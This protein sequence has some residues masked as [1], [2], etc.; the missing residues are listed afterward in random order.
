MFI[1][2]ELKTPGVG[3]WAL[4]GGVCGALF[5]VAQY[6]L[7]MINHVEIVLVVLGMI[8][9]VTE[10][11]TMVGG[12]F[13]ALVGG[14]I[15]FTG[16]VMAFLPNEFEF[17]LSDER[18]LNALGDA[19]ISGLIAIGVMA[20]G[21]V[22]FIYALPRTSLGRRLSVTS[23]VSATSAGRLEALMSDLVG[24]SG[25]AC[26]AMHPGGMVLVDGEQYGAR[27]E[28][29]GFVDTGTPIK[30][31]AV[32]FGELIVEPKGPHIEGEDSVR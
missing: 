25:T 17:D 27:V 13:L 8:L 19:A 6:S 30:V 22:G 26:D 16:L 12:G 21:I 2:F 1:I 5:L 32:R 31:I 23:E 15:I 10:F 20:A 29:G 9:V 28:H 18:Y 4:L 14:L 3:L 24:R 7:D 11:L